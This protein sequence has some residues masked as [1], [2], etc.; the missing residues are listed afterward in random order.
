MRIV[1][2]AHICLLAFLICILLLP[3][4]GCRVKTGGTLDTDVSMRH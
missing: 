1:H 4:A 2:T 3:G